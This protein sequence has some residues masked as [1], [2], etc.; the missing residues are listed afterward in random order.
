MKIL[1]G[2]GKQ[3]DGDVSGTCWL[4]EHIRS[5]NDSKD[6]D[7]EVQ[8]A[9]KDF[10]RTIAT[11]KLAFSEFAS[12]SEDFVQ[13][14]PEASLLL[15]SVFNKFEQWLIGVE[16]NREKE[17]Q[18]AKRAKAKTKTKT[19]TKIKTKAKVGKSKSKKG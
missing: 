2:H 16:K 11:N 17:V 13:L 18:R 14:F 19:K 12:V 4:C 3:H 5:T 6:I 15:G 7:N 8:E 9:Y 10:D 1:E